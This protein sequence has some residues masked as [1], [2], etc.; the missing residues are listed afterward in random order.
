[1]HSSQWTYA[2]AAELAQ[3]LGAGKVSARP[4][5]PRPPKPMRGSLSGLERL[6]IASGKALERLPAGPRRGGPVTSVRL[7]AAVADRMAC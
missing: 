1:M 2:S 6:D 5:W 3:A 4:H 7:A